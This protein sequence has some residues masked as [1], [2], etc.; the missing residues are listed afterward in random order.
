DARALVADHERTGPWPLAVPDVEV[1]VADAAGQDPDPDLAMFRLIED[2]LLDRDRLT[3]LF[4]D[5]GTH[6]SSVP[7]MTRP[8]ATLAPGLERRTKSRGSGD[9][10]GRLDHHRVREDVV[11][12]LLGRTLVRGID[13]VDEPGQGS[14]PNHEADERQR[15]EGLDNPEGC[16]EGDPALDRLVLGQGRA[17]AGVP[18]LHS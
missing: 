7:D 9:R 1:G 17:A 2:Q 11:T 18:D 4:Q 3:R 12:A 16:A 10:V 13:E 15:V 5:G 6:K 14:H 8:G